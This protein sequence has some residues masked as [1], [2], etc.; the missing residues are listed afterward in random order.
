[1]R[2]YILIYK[3]ALFTPRV[4]EH[5][6]VSSNRYEIIGVGGVGAKKSGSF[7]QWV[8]VQWDYWGFWAATWVICFT[9][10]SRLLGYL[11]V[12]RAFR[13]LSSVAASCDAL[14]IPYEEVADVNSPAFLASL[15]E[16][17]VEL[18][19]CFQQQIFKSEL[20]NL[21]SAGCVNVHT[22]ILPGYRGFKPVFWMHARREPEMGVT[23]HRME[24]KIDA[25][26]IVVERRWK[27]RP[28]SSVLENLFWSYQCA[29][30]C[31]VD[32]IER[33]I[34]SPAPTARSS[35]E[36]YYRAPTREERILEV[37]AGT[38]MI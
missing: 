28:H 10:L 34:G 29:S 4:V 26:E 12:P 38:R 18:I 17:G 5:V 14:E 36:G 24:K 11:P 37:K 7:L 9:T 16:R 3:S 33:L 31:I 13:R 1:M 27:R 2:V 20:L 25:G 6:A 8:R 21:P 22:G 30:H 35:I 32:A 19:V 23:V 15:R